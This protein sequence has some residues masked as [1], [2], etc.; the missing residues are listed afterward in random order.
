MPSPNLQ[1]DVYVAPAAPVVYADPDPSRHHFPPLAVTV[2][3]SASAAVIVDSPPTQPDAEAFLSWFEQTFPGRQ[4]QSVFLTHSHADHFFGFTA[5][6]Q[7]HPNAHFVATPAVAQGVE[8]FL[9]STEYEDLWKPLFPGDGLIPAKTNIVVP[10]ALGPTADDDSGFEFTLDGFVLRAHDVPRGDTAHNSFLHVPQLSLVVAGDLV[11][12][13]CHQF[14]GETSTPEKR[15]G[16]LAALDAVEALGP[17]MVVPGHYHPSQ[18]FGAYLVDETRRYAHAFERELGRAESAE[19]L[20][21]RMR[22]LFPDRTSFLILDLGCKAS[23]A[24]KGA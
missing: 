1:V 12:G 17:K 4:I 18:L 5:L 9:Q 23:F 20:D 24:Q 19:G 8:A 6:K 14:Y 10:D 3:H 15:A 21:R 16:W 2:I 7:R 13:D 22:E 11:Y